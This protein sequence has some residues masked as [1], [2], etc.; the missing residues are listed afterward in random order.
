M[1]WQN[2]KNL[3]QLPP[4]SFRS[5]YGYA[6]E[7]LAI[8]RALQCGFNLFFK[9]W[10]DSAYDAVLDYDGNLFRIEIKG[11]SIGSLS[12]TSGGRSGQQISKTAGS[13][14]HLLRK[15]DCDFLLGIDSLN[16]DCYIIPIEVIHI[17]GLQSLSYNRIELF[18]EKWGIFLGLKIRNRTIFSP[19]DILNGFN[20][21][22]RNYLKNIC[23]KYN[24]SISKGRNYPWDGFGRNNQIKN[25]SLKD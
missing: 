7:S 19:D 4:G 22:T 6:G 17:F 11:S 14:Q 13:R 2:Y 20:G 3:S 9:A 8:G 15:T 18:K 1:S 23:C 10:R 24:I 25:I 5:I 21:C 12:V 16:A